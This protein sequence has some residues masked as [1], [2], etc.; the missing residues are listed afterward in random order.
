MSTF[1]DLAEVH[2]AL[3]ETR[4]ARRTRWFEAYQFGMQQGTGIT[5][6]RLD[7]D[8]ACVHLDNE[9][10]RLEGERDAL[11]AEARGLEYAG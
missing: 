2:R 6:L 10:T 4:V 8:A 3:A 7:C 1:A 9:I 11:S 5:Q